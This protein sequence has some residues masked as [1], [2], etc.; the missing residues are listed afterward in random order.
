MKHR[1]VHPRTVTCIAGDTPVQSYYLV[2]ES[3]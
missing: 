3:L 1:P 2:E